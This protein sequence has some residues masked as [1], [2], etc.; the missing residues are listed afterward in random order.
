M[1]NINTSYSRF[2]ALLTLA[3]GLFFVPSAKAQF[4]QYY[5]YAQVDHLVNTFNNAGMHDHIPV[6][7]DQANFLAEGLYVYSDGTAKL[8]S[9]NLHDVFNPTYRE[10][11]DDVLWNTGDI[12][13]AIEAALGLLTPDEEMVARYGNPWESIL[14][15]R[16]D[17]SP[18]AFYGYPEGGGGDHDGT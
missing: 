11:F 16:A 4:A 14:G 8:D 5:T 2:I 7:F 13:I 17:A 6:E 3:V 15:W 1:N 18:Y 10:I 9:G 12:D